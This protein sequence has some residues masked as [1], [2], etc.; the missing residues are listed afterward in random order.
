MHTLAGDARDRMHTLADGTRERLH[1]LKQSGTERM[2]DMADRTR[3]R[4]H[5]MADKTRSKMQRGKA[6]AESFIERQPLL[7]GAIALIVGTAI[8]SA[9]PSTPQE[10]KAARP[11]AG[12]AKRLKNKAKTE[13][14]HG[15]ERGAEMATQALDNA[16]TKIEEA[17]PGRV[18]VH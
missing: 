15:I 7:A 11:L 18:P 14:V 1:G 2:H 4:S 9:I 10:R 8:A 16:T 6:R 3:E 5:R 13:L 12:T 17:M